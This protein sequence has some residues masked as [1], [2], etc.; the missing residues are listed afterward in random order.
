MTPNRARFVVLGRRTAPD[1]TTEKFRSPTVGGF[2]TLAV[3][4]RISDDLC[5]Q[6]PT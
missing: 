3:A 2:K 1:G 6:F 4:K 5:P